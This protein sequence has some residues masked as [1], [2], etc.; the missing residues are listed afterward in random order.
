[1]KNFYSLPKAA[2]LAV[3]FTLCSCEQ[4]Q[5]SDDM[6]TQK[7][8]MV[9]DTEFYALAGGMMLDHYS[10]ANPESALNSVMISG[11]QQD[12]KI[13][14][15]DFRPATGQLYGLGSTS[16]IYVIDPD[17]G[18]AR[19]IGTGPFTPM[20]SGDVTGFDFN[21]TVDR[22]RVVTSSGQNLR[23]NPETGMV[24][25]TDLMINGSDG[26]MI[27]G[28]AYTNNMAGAATT[29]LY[30]IDVTSDKL[31]MQNPPNNGTL[32]AVG[33]LNLKVEGDGGFDI[34]PM[35]TALAL[36]EVNKKATLMHVDLMTGNAT[37]LAKYD[38][39]MMYHGIA[40]PTNPVAYAVTASN[41]LLIF[42]PEMPEMTISKTITGLMPGEMLWGI[43]FRPVNGQLYAL[44]STSRLYTINASSGAATAAG[45]MFTTLLSGTDFGFD[46]NPLVDRIRIIS[47]TGQNLRVNPNDGAVTVDG[48][49]NPATT[50]VSAAAY[51]NNFA[52]TTTTALFDIDVNSDKLYQQTPPNN[53]TLVEIGSLGV[54]ADAATGFDIGGRSGT[55]WAIM[56]SAGATKLYEINRMTGMAMA[57]GNFSSAVTGFTVGLGF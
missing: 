37:I 14:S 2:G 35:G 5:V 34:S 4:E 51:S 11:L 42:N 7:Q 24:A 39:S 47:N 18:M 16:R 3:L 22:I 25:A 1:M 41:N 17:S 8:K 49:L 57:K 45:A 10:T 27:T 13:L 32:V 26:A 43:D 56:T 33:K 19:A 50:G 28:V 30:D 44:G 23:L 20:L 12:E 21:P 48:A 15:I 6:Q 31:F 55:A 46:F 40:I 53:G 29:T 38:K 54:D 9:P 52:G 36:Y